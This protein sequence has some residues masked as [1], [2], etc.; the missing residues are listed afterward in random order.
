MLEPQEGTMFDL[1]NCFLDMIGFNAGGGR[2]KKHFR[3]FSYKSSKYNEIIHLNENISMQSRNTMQRLIPDGQRY[4]GVFQNNTMRQSLENMPT[5]ERSTSLNIKNRQL[6]D[7]SVCHDLTSDD[8]C[9]IITTSGDELSEY[10]EL[11][12]VGVMESPLDSFCTMCTSSFSFNNCKSCE[13]N[14]CSSKCSVESCCVC[15][16]DRSVER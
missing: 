14:R 13:G 5:R 4:F 2:T 11:S 1:K 15:C 7:D 16:T 6:D 10:N 12:D 8:L 9:T 3:E